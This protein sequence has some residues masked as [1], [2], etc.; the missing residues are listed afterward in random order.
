MR[1]SQLIVG[2]G[3]ASASSSTR[4]VDAG[5]VTSPDGS[6]AVA[7]T[8]SATATYDRMTQA[9]RIGSCSWRAGAVTGPVR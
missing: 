2:H 7:A 3:R 4:W 6:A 9:Q 8:P 5:P 1:V